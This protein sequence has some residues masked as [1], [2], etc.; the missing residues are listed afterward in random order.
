VCSIQHEKGRKTGDTTS[1]M[2][3]NIGENRTPPIW[4]SKE[5]LLEDLETDIAP[6]S[7]DEIESVLKLAKR[8]RDNI[9]H[10]G[11]HY[12]GA[13]YYPALFVDVSGFLIERY[14]D[15]DDIPELKTMTAYRDEYDRRR[16]DAESYPEVSVGIGHGR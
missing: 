12:Q 4:R 3:L 7:V 1:V 16:T 9:A 2:R 13:H 6:D 8:K 5:R 14:A 15:T 11:F 10:F